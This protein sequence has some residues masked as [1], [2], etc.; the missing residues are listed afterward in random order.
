MHRCKYYCS[1]AA[2]KAIAAGDRDVFKYEVR[3]AAK[4]GKMYVDDLF[5][6]VVAR[7]QVEMAEDMLGSDL[8]ID[9]NEQGPMRK[10][11]ALHDAASNRD[12]AMINMLLAHGADPRIPNNQS[13]TPLWITK[14]YC[15]SEVFAKM[16][17]IAEQLPPLKEQDPFRV[18]PFHRYPRSF[19]Y[20]WNAGKEP[21]SA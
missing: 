2:E 3:K 13:I 12:E 16:S 21:R 6:I 7:G 17:E 18:R 11:T 14:R 19:L 4:I 9:V 5:R 10:N 15:S 1:T 8:G 20:N